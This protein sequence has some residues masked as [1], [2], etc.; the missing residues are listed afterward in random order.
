MTG[1]KFESDFCELLKATG[2][3]A[4]NIPKNKYGAQPFDIIA[5]CGNSI[6]AVD[7]KV[8]EKSVFPLSRIEDN[9]WLSFQLMSEKTNAKVGIMIY[10]KG[11]IY[12][13][14]YPF[15]KEHAEAGASSVRFTRYR[16]YWSKEMIKNTIGRY[17][18]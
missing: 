3:W 16:K 1:E 18:E 7:C 5:I 8:C 13:V 12:Y 2:Y 11:D 9:Q 6:L 14:P 17:I 4:L 15:L 10:Y